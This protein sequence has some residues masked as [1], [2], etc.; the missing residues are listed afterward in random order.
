M[1]SMGNGLAVTGKKG[2]P[3]AARGLCLAVTRA[4]GRTPVT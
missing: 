3:A 2:G 4:A 1:D